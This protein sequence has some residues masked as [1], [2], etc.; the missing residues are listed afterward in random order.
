M[1]RK[2]VL[3]MERAI[4]SAE[5]TSVSREELASSSRNNPVSEQLPF[6]ILDE[7]S[8]AFPKLNATQ[9]SLLIK[10]STPGEERNPTS[11][12]RECITAFT[13]YLVNDVPD[14]DLVG[15]RICNPENV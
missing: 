7:T 10:F 9:R 14:R 12:L 3:N 2:V 4:P 5:V 15:L 6:L 13:D 1:A 8:K 11:Y